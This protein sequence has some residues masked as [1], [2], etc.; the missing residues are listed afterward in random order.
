MYTVPEIINIAKVSQYLAANDVA[1][2]A[3]F[4]QRL[5]PRLPL[6]LYME[7]RAV[8][9]MQGMDGDYE[10]LRHTANYLYDLCGRYGLAA[11]RIVAAGGGGT[12]VSPTS[13]SYDGRINWIRVTSADMENETDYVNTSLDGE[14]FRVFANW[15]PRYLEYGTEWEYLDG[16][17]VRLIGWD[18]TTQDLEFYVDLRDESTA[19]NQSVQWESIV[20]KPLAGLEYDLTADTLIT[21]PTGTSSFSTILISIIPNGYNY[22]WDS[23]FAFSFTWPEQPTATGAGTMQNYTFRYISS[24]DKWV[25]EG[26]SI[27]IPI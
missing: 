8:E 24:Q 13:P 2:G 1:R 17:G 23:K 15:I 10:T 11:A 26:Q 6:M 14:V 3:L 20:G 21:N 7:R 16:G 4:G 18:S 19:L 5:D 27:D 25:C 9:W 12:V 22:T